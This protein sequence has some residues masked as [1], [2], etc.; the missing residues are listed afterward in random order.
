KQLPVNI[1]RLIWNAK[2]AFQ[3][4]PDGKSDM[5][6]AYVIRSVRELCNR[7]VVVRGEDELSKEAQLNAT[8]LFKIL[9]RVTGAAKRVLLTHRLNKPAFDFVVGE[10]Q[11][12]F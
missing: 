12:K 8:L 1:R 2:K 6:P 11:S 4:M 10:V 7:L 9:V 3:I 5:S